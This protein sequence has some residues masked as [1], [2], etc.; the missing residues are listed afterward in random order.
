MSTNTVADGDGEEVAIKW[1]LHNSCASNVQLGVISNVC[2]RWRDVTLRTVASEAVALASK[3][4]VGGDDATEPTEV[5]AK[6]PSPSLVRRLLI[7]DMARE[8]LARQGQHE[9]NQSNADATIAATLK[10]NFKSNTDGNFCLAWFAPSGIQTIPV[11]LDCEDGDEV[12]EEDG[13]QFDFCGKNGAHD[14]ARRQSRIGRKANAG[15]TVTCCSEWRGHRHATEVLAPFGYSTDF[16]RSVLDKS[17]ELAFGSVVSATEPSS[18][19]SSSPPKQ[20][21]TTSHQYNPTYSVRGAT[22]ARPEGFCLCVDSDYIEHANSSD[23]EK[24]CH[25]SNHCVPSCVDGWM[26][27]HDKHNRWPLQNNFGLS[28]V[29]RKRKRINLAKALL[30]RMV[31]STRRK[32]PLLRRFAEA[33][34]DE[35]AERRP[36][37]WER[38]QRAVQFLNSDR[39]QAIKFITP[40]F[41]CGPAYGPVTMFVVAITTEDGC[42]LSGR[43]TRFELGHLYPLSSRDMQY[44][45]SPV[46]IATGKKESGGGRN[47]PADCVTYGRPLSARSRAS[48]SD[49]DNNSTDTERSVHCLCKFDSGDPFNPKDLSIDDPTEDCI[50]RG[51]TGPGLWHCYVAIFD[52]KDSVIRVDGCNEPKRTR[53]HCGM[54]ASDEED[55]SADN[56][57]N[58]GKFVGSGALDGLSI[59]SDHQFDMSLCYG[60][61]EGECG[62]GAIAELAVFKGRMDDSDIEKLEEYLMEKHGLLSVKQ[63]REFVAEQNF[64]RMKPLNIECHLQEDEWRRQAHALIEQ[65]RPWNLEGRVPLRV[66]ANHHSVAW[67]RTNDI[68]GSAI[69]IS[70]IGAKSSNGSSDW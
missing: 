69:R 7:T 21:K 22:L 56:P 54:A 35:K 60:E 36:L 27:D 40:Y 41:E 61:I 64:T 28:S 8:L 5:G 3:V 70:R 29:Q 48:S 66:A 53:E 9:Q 14:E 16:I 68:T 58:S 42:F 62:Q 49:D 30:P 34:A 24:P 37:P 45:M 65:R 50:C 11:S 17:T 47:G 19:A 32:Y 6:N 55:D 23:F 25:A 39:S 15:R 31:M 2:Q 44:D 38:R 57:V 18:P 51:C 13:F 33:D 63:K 46:S 52:G 59:G 20:S 1:F 10:Q 43:S 67:H 4:S 26:N 12:S